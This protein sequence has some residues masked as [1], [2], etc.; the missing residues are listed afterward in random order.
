MAYTDHFRLVDDVTAH[1]DGVVAAVDPFTQ[2]RYVGFYSVSAAAVVELALK[3][4]IISFASANHPI[5]GGY[6]ETKYEQINGRIKLG[7]ITVD[8]LGPFGERYKKRFERLLDRVESI[9][10]RRRR[11]SVK[12]SYANLLNCRHKFAHEGAIP[13]YS[14]YADVKKGFEAGK[15]VLG[16]LAKTLS[17]P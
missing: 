14:T 1:L 13:A 8:H 3:E 6:V 7:H 12:S 9:E 4:I 5:F 15:I 2:S 11:F 16:C 17:F 10:L